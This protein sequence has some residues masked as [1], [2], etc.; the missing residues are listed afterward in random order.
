MF[1]VKTITEQLGGSVSVKSAPGKGSEFSVSFP[2]VN[3]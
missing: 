3:E 1:Y 2:A